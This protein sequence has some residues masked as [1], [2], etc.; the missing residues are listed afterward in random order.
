[1]LAARWSRDLIAVLALALLGLVLALIPGGGWVEGALLSL[2]VLIL[3]GYALAA[4]FF[5]PGAIP[6]AERTVYTVALS[7]AV[8]G[9]GGVLTQIVFNLDRGVWVA[10]LLAATVAACWAAQR[11]RELLPLDS[12][13]PRFQLP[14]IS[15]L[16]IAATLVAIGI[17]A[18]AFGI[19][20]NGTSDSRADAHFAELWVLSQPGAS[21]S[22]AEPGV[23][24]GVGNHEGRSVSFLVRAARGAKVLARWKVHLAR[25]DRWQTS[26]RTPPLSAAKPLR[27]TLLREGRVYREAFLR[28]DFES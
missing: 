28:S 3:P 2:L 27:V 26:L 14:G 19:A 21:P 10:L 15:P 4:A 20:V 13:A 18:T 25:G 7:I 16:A 1:M 6:A 22:S 8:A 24:I 23:S 9:L 11:R 17:A 5:Q 12:A